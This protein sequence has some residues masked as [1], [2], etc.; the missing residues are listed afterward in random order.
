V[1]TPVLNRRE[2]MRELVDS[3]WAQSLEPTQFELVVVDDASSDGTPEMLEELQPRSPCRLTVHR[4]PGH[5]GA[6]RARNVALGLA[7]APLVAFTDSDCRVS[8]RWLELGLAAFERDPS[9]AFVTGPILNKP[10]QQV[11]FFSIGG[12]PLPGENPIYPLANAFYRKDVILEVGGFDESAWLREVY[13]TAMEFSDVDMAYRV[14]GR[15]YRNAFVP[16][17]VVYHQV[18]KASLWQWLLWTMKVAHV[19]EVLDRYPVLRKSLLWKGPFLSPDHLRYYLA[20][21]GVLSAL[22]LGPWWGLL[23]LPH[24]L[25][26]AFVPG[27]ALSVKA[28]LV[29]PARVALL[30]LRQTML[31]GFLL[32]GSVRARCLVL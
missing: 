18:F 8:P 28:L 32:W 16:D 27:R 2:L 29:A 14:R 25:R 10:E 30:T 19:P 12:N 13:G 24:I 22:L 1:V 26:T 11:T 7:R 9:V 3:L 4:L 15:G 23:A 5:S 21:A 6:V 17:L 31:S 20:I